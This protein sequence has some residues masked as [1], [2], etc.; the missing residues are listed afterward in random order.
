MKSPLRHSGKLPACYHLFIV[1]P[2]GFWP[3]SSLSAILDPGQGHAGV[4]ACAG[5]SR[6]IA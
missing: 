4:T 6:V 5:F 1:I 2:A 3:E